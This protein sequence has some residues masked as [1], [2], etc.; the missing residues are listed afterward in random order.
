MADVDL[1]ENVPM[2]WFF[3]NQEDAHSVKEAF[4]EMKS[5]DD[6]FVSGR[7][8]KVVY[9]KSRFGSIEII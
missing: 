4:K 6:I 2:I 5:G 8:I 9:D 1:P 3:N 7:G